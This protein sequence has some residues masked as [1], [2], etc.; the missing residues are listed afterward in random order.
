MTIV[1]AGYNTPQ[2]SSNLADYRTIGGFQVQF[3]PGCAKRF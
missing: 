3:P 2:L 1:F